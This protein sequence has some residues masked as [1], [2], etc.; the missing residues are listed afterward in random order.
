VK[1]TTSLD[2]PVCPFCGF[3]YTLDEA[4]YFNESGYDLECECGGHFHVRPAASWMWTCEAKTFEG[5]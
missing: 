4:F 5:G 1:R 3:S 2:G